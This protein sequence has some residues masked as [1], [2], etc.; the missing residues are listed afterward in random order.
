MQA[1]LQLLLLGLEFMQVFLTFCTLVTI[2]FAEEVPLTVK[3]HHRLS[4]VAPLLEDQQQ[5]GI[6]LSKL[7]PGIFTMDGA[8]GKNTMGGHESNAN[9]QHAKS[10]IEEDQ[11]SVL[12]DGPGAVLVNLLTSLRHLPPGMHSVL[13]VMALT[14]VRGPLDSY[15]RILF[16]DSTFLL[17]VICLFI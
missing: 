9:S 7:K 13:I 3:E 6:E 11:N 14:W 10:K 17:S 1:V 16:Y 12:N 5:N 4:D 15:I 2:Y 8:N